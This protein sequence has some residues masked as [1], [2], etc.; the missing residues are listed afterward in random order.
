MSA[1][2]EIAFAAA[3]HSLCLFT[4]TGFS[5]AV[6]ENS[7]PSWQQLLESICDMHPDGAAMRSA[8]FPM[9][10]PS[11]LSLEESA[12]V[13]SLQLRK[14][15]RNIHTEIA[16]K[17]RS[18]T[19]SGDNSVIMDFL[20][21]N[22]L[23][24]VTTNY[25]KLIETLC[26]PA[27]CHSITPGYPIPRGPA[28]V[29]VYHV[30]GSVDAPKEMVVTSD[31]YFKFMHGESYFSRKLSTVLH[32]NTVVIL[33]YS[34]GDTN[35]K[36]IIS[37]YR[38]FSRN[39]VIT[40]NLFLVSRGVVAQYLK[41]Y[42]SHCY[43]IRVL[44]NLDIHKFFLEVTNMLPE[45]SAQCR[46]AIR[47]L[48]E[49]LYENK[50]FVDDYLKIETSFLEI[51]SSV[52]AVG[53]SIDDPD[54]VKILDNIL[55]RKM[56]FTGIVNAWEQYD[57][58]AIWLCHLGSILELRDTSICGTYLRAVKR[59]MDKMSK[60]RCLGYSWQAYQSWSTRWLGIL[61]ANRHLIREYIR[62]NSIDPDALDV[63]A[64]G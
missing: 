52:A 33:G 10:K 16:Q 59:S 22:P 27:R 7:A 9:N 53:K 56:E 49:V 15:D 42:Y 40:G 25:D 50:N 28:D 11:P 30:H 34:L 20:Q 8:L 13:I 36:K 18:L 39:H 45:V 41:D 38:G 43:G 19:L 58:M 4:G 12:Q 21:R 3:T 61:D 32:E 24:V 37:E 1:Y 29:K 60:N 57:H 44:D 2:Y 23:H 5:K 51:T 6:T 14:Y 64:Q 54:I 47:S 46:G 63:V 31:D 48:Q 17:I 35:L 26:H 55:K 62:A